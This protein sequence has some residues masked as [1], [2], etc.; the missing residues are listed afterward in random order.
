MRANY[1][2]PY[3]AEDQYTIFED[4]W[5]GEQILWTLTH[6][7]LQVYWCMLLCIIVQYVRLRPEIY[8]M[9]ESE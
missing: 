4:K 9:G 6:A 5:V 8:G 2:I 3:I 7:Y 1:S